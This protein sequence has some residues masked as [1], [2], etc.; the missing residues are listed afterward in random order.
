MCRRPGCSRGG[1]PRLDVQLVQTCTLPNGH[2]CVG[3][4]SCDA[5]CP[6]RWDATGTRRVPGQANRPAAP[7]PF[8]LPPAAATVADG[9]G[10]GGGDDNA[11][12]D[13]WRQVTHTQPGQLDNAENANGHDNATDGQ[14]Q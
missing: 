2:Q 5:L 14:R 7:R 6:S 12:V 8:A 9:R 10:R 4:P 3:R 1:M 13:T 11:A